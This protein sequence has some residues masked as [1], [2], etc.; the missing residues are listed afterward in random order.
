MEIRAI[1]P[2]D[3]LPLAHL[4]GRVEQF[5]PQEVD[6]AL[7]LIDAASGRTVSKLSGH[8]GPV[9]RKDGTR[10][11]NGP[12]SAG[13]IAV[14]PDGRVFA[15]T[16]DRQLGLWTQ[17]G[18]HTRTLHGAAFDHAAGGFSPDRRWLVS[19][20]PLGVVTLIDVARGKEAASLDLRRSGVKTQEHAAAS[21]VFLPNGRSFLLGTRGGSLYELAVDAEASR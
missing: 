17:G 1:A 5:S 2:P 6:C 3:R 12:L 9:T 21:L 14:S 7:E 10:V 4:L 19:A 16:A 15:T 20:S 11:K 8:T 18:G 13:A